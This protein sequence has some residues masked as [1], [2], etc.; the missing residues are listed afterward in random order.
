MRLRV[1]SI[2]FLF[3]L[4]VLACGDRFPKEFPAP[5]FKLKSPVTNRTV[6]LSDYK[7]RPVIMYWFTSW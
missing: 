7:G 4:F 5:D 3:T 1:L 2:V 6:R